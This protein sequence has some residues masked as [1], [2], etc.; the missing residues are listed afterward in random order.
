MRQARIVLFLSTAALAALGCVS[1]DSGP[2]I[3]GMQSDADIF[4]ADDAM[5]SLPK[6]GEN[7]ARS[8]ESDL[9]GNCAEGYVCVSKPLRTRQCRQECSVMQQPCP[10]YDGPGSSFCGAYITDGNNNILGNYCVIICE[11]RSGSFPGCGNGACDGTCPGATSC[12][13]HPTDFDLS[14]CEACL[15]GVC[16]N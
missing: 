1:N 2:D 16:E 13:L 14:T 12:E 5:P 9:R 4:R 15:S 7:C 3:V 6:D 8:E 11:D 10:G